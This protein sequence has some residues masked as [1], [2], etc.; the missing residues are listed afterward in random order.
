MGRRLFSLIKRIKNVRNIFGSNA[1]ARIADGDCKRSC[2]VRDSQANATVISEAYSVAQQI[3]ENLANTCPVYPQRRQPI[4]NDEVKRQSSAVDQVTGQ[5]SRFQNDLAR[6]G[7]FLDHCHIAC[8]DLRYI[9]HIADEALEM[10]RTFA[11]GLK[12]GP[13][14]IWQAFAISLWSRNDH[15]AQP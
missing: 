11:D 13:V 3:Q 12:I 7:K 10:F 1:S 14:G 5:I 15:L 8:L 9:Q 2:I 4:W 6:I